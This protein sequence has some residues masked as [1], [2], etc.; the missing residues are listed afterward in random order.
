MLAKKPEL[1]PIRDLRQRESQTPHDP[2]MESTSTSPVTTMSF[3]TSVTVQ[4]PMPVDV[5]T[6]VKKADLNTLVNLPELQNLITSVVESVI[7]KIKDMPCDEDQTLSLTAARRLTPPLT[8]PASTPGHDHEDQASNCPKL[9]LEVSSEPTIAPTEDGTRQSQ[10]TDTTSGSSWT[11]RKVEA[12]II[13]AIT[14]AKTQNLQTPGLLDRERIFFKMEEHKVLD[15]LHTQPASGLNHSGVFEIAHEVHRRDCVMADQHSAARL[16]EQLTKIPWKRC[17][18]FFQDLDEANSAAAKELRRRQPNRPR[19]ASPRGFQ[20]RQ[21]SSD[22]G[23]HY[24]CLEYDGVGIVEAVVLEKLLCEIDEKEEMFTED[25]WDTL[26]VFSVRLRG[27]ADLGWEKDSIA[28]EPI[29]FLD[30]ESANEEAIRL[31]IEHISGFQTALERHDRLQNLLRRAQGQPGCFKARTGAMWAEP[32]EV[33]V[34][35]GRLVGPSASFRQQ[36][37]RS[38]AYEAQPT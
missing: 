15:F 14:A 7:R 23:T 33:W 26:A 10:T 1:S 12:Q 31:W 38:R 28:R 6:A 9:Q 29:V 5:M 11:W 3:Q 8:T 32:L 36:R 30:L 24:L 18:D 13:E 4:V 34:E 2:R 21:E 35:T 37:L 22:D 19:F 27:E 20:V 16:K 25:D 17:G